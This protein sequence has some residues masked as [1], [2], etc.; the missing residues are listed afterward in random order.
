MQTR[1]CFNGGEI[2]PEMSARADMDVYARSCTRLENWEVRQMGGVRRRRGMRRFAEALD[3]NSR[4]LAFVYSYGDEVENDVFLVEVNRDY[5]RMWNMNGEKE[6][7]FVSGDE[8][9]GE[10]VLNA[11]EVRGCQINSLLVLTGPNMAPLVL[12]LGDSV[13]GERVWTLEKFWL[14]GEAW[15]YVNEARDYQ[16]RLEAYAG[17]T[18]T[19]YKVTFD[20]KE[21][22]GEAE[23]IEGERLRASFWVEPQEVR[24]RAELTL[25]GVKIVSDLEAKKKGERIAIHGE[26]VE[27]YWV[28]V[29]DMPGDVYVE[30]RDSPSCYPDNFKPA[31]N[32]EGFSSAQTVTSVHQL[33]GGGEVKKGTKVAMREGYWEYYTCIRDFTEEDMVMGAYSYADY[34]T[35]FARGLAIGDAVPCRGKWAFACSGVWYG[36][37]EVR[38]CY[39]THS[40]LDG[41]WETVGVSFSRAEGASNIPLAGDESAEMCYLRLFITRSKFMNNESLKAGYPSDGCANS[42]EVYGYRHDMMLR[43]IGEIDGETLFECEDAVKLL[44]VGV[45]QVDDWSW[46]AFGERYGYPSVAGVYNMRLVFGGTAEQPQTLWMSAVNDINN[47][48]T[49][50]GSEDGAIML[51][52]ATTT[53]NPICWMQ[54]LEKRFIIGTSE[55]EWAVTGGDGGAITSMNARVE[56]HG[57]VGSMQG[58]AYE[59]QERM[60]Y[61]GRG[62]KRVYDIGY[63]QD[64]QQLQS[65]DLTVF[66]PHIMDEHG[67][68]VSGTLM[69]KP[70]TVAVFALADGQVAL[71]TYNTMHN[72]AAWHRWVTDGAVKCVCALPNGREADRLFMVVERDGVAE[73]E[74]VDEE[75]PYHDEGGRGYESVLVTNALGNILEE[76]VERRPKGAVAVRFG[77]DVPTEALEVCSPGTDWVRLATH[78]VVVNEGWREVITINKWDYENRVGIRVHGET[79]C[80]ILALQG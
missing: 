6:A 29:K 74:V 36:S 80:H 1:V 64:I 62:G 33:N 8:G 34:P 63:R 19:L 67:G 43:C 76:P 9:V 77:A 55:A 59:G 56:R 40:L 30:G 54:M 18:R 75:S 78:E 44:W 58:M 57:H 13:E 51:T 73:I 70:D 45:R 49:T 79:G 5:V 4:L 11:D 31:E 21:E 60:L 68:V 7:E 39:D 50:G 3:G 61:V 42:L 24:E 65:A 23:M 25:N 27:S 35:F 26:D 69:S 53:Q 2:S 71:C 32:T 52:L 10:F 16:I 20:E 41:E 46:Q 15:A 48:S 12:K 38:R 17:M 66:A 72:V 14:H 28:C 22:E 47:F 37:Y